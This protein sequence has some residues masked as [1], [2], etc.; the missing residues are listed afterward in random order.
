MR[1]SELLEIKKLSIP[2]KILLLEEFWNEIAVQQ[3]KIP[4][5]ESHKEEL[6][7]RLERFR[8]DPGNL[9]SLEELKERISKRI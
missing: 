6:N 7:K 3:S 9:I 4:V 1:I 5:P 8:R 2:E